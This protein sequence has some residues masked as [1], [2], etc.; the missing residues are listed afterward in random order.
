MLDHVGRNGQ[1]TRLREAISAVL[2]EDGV[3]TRD[4]GGDA[5]TEEVTAAI[6][7]RCA[8]GE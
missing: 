7:A 6:V 5:T 2:N 1:A 3:R 8:P 4:L